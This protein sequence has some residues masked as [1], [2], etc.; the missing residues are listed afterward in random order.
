MVGGAILTAATIASTNDMTTKATTV[1]ARLR[2]G[3]RL[4]RRPRL[5]L[6]CRR[7]RARRVPRRAA[8][9]HVALVPGCNQSARGGAFFAFSAAAAATTV[10]AET[11]SVQQRPGEG[12]AQ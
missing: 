1:C 9:A 4:P 2:R 10:A 6:R 5:G 12:E 8:V 11:T 7:C 3:R